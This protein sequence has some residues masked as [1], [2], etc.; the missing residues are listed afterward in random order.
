[1]IFSRHISKSVK[2]INKVTSEIQELYRYSYHITTPQNNINKIELCIIFDKDTSSYIVNM[3]S[4]DLKHNLSSYYLSSCVF[5]RENKI[6]L[7]L[8]SF[9]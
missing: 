5:S 1:M 2:Y 6:V 7:Y 9:L 8:K 3:A 4:N